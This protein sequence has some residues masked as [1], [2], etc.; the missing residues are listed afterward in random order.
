MNRRRRPSTS[1]A[2]SRVVL[3]QAAP[4]LEE[5]AVAAAA[6]IGA[7]MISTAALGV[8]VKRDFAHRMALSIECPSSFLNEKL[9]PHYFDLRFCDN[10]LVTPRWKHTR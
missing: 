10:R 1:T 2:I 9:K 5:E 8:A 4:G 3:A 7:L 6:L